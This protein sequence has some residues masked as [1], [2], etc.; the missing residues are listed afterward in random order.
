MNWLNCRNLEQYFGDWKRVYFI[1]VTIVN[2][3]FYFCNAV[4]NNSNLFSG[5]V[6][7]VDN[8]IAA[9]WPTV[10]NPYNHIQIILR[11]D[12]QQFCAK[13]IGFVGAGQAVVVIVLSV[14][15]VP[16]VNAPAIVRGIAAFLRHCRSKCTNHYKGECV[17]YRF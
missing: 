1:T 5:S 9:V 4:G 12:H 15:C 11:V 13:S 7:E 14:G 17:F 3:Q 16:A 10:S 8:A 2:R 6:W